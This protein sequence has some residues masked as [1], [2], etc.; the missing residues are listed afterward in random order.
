M[1][2]INGTFLTTASNG[3][4]MLLL[5]CASCRNAKKKSRCSGKDI[6]NCLTYSS[7]RLPVEA[8][9]C[10]LGIYP[11]HFIPGHKAVPAIIM[12]L[13][14]ARRAIM[15]SME[16]YR[17]PKGSFLEAIRMGA[18]S[19]LEIWL[20]MQSATPL[21]SSKAWLVLYPVRGGTLAWTNSLM[22]IYRCAFFSFTRRL[23]LFVTR[24]IY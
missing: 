12:C 5:C 6:I 13:F 22:V 17:S 19:T 14:Q 9:L 4:I 10:P 16:K 11:D 18:M 8:K 1:V 2:R 3:L 20:A 7:Y 15:L 24:F 23:L 21:S